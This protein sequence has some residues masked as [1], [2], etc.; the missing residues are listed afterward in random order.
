MQITGTLILLYF[1]ELTNRIRYQYPALCTIV[2]GANEYTIYLATVL[3]ST[4]KAINV[5][6]N[7]QN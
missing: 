3:K 4:S 2:Y 5:C 7:S 1:K 6:C